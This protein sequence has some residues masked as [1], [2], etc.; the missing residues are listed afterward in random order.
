MGPCTYALCGRHSPLAPV[1]PFFWS[2]GRNSA[3]AEGR[4]DGLSDGPSHVFKR[5][6][7]E[8]GIPG[9]CRRETYAYVLPQPMPWFPT[10]SIGKAARGGPRF[11]FQRPPPAVGQ[12]SVSFIVCSIAGNRK[13]RGFFLN[14]KGFQ[15][16][17][18]VFVH[19]LSVPS[20]QPLSLALCS[21]SMWVFR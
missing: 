8:Q 2:D 16:L 12:C 20:P 5:R 15:R 1:L 13:R 11:A 7:R 10:C 18:H 6:R 21:F 3:E 19:P 17:R 9:L 14:L 4:S